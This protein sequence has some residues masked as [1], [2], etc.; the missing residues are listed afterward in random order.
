MLAI[1]ATCEDIDDAREAQLHALADLHEWGKASADAIEALRQLNQD[2][3][4]GSE[5][6]Y[7]AYLL[8]S[9]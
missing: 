3:L 7:V 6:E 5:T 4:A 1:L 2:T 9:A 8:G